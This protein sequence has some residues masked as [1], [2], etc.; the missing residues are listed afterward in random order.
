MSALKTRESG[1]L[2]RAIRIVRNP[3]AKG[4]LRDGKA[5]GHWIAIATGLLERSSAKAEELGLSPDEVDEQV[6]T[7]LALEAVSTVL[8]SAE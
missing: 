3:M 4:W 5:S 1:I 2:L 6:A 8:R 7:M